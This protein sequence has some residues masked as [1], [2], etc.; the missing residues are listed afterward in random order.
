M[1]HAA[2]P[3]HLK[4]RAPFGERLLRLE[5]LGVFRLRVDMQR[6]DGKAGQRSH[7]DLP[8]GPHRVILF[9]GKRSRTVRLHGSL[10]SNSVEVLREAVLGGYGFGFMPDFCVSADIE[11]G[12]LVEVLPH[13]RYPEIT[14]QAVYPGNR[15]IAAKVRA[16]VNFL[17]RRL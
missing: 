15:Q 16:F 13:W 11:A 8:T 4:P 10:T 17:A 1:R 7:A 6:R 2:E 14:I 9:R 5:I 3:P 12:R